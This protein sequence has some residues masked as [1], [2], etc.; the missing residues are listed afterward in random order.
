MCQQEPKQIRNISTN[1]M[2]LCMVLFICLNKQTKEMGKRKKF[3]KENF[4]IGFTNKHI[5][6]VTLEVKEEKKKRT[7]KSYQTRDQ[8]NL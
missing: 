6:S 5:D 2:W 3:Q 7:F 1:C 8:P 4:S